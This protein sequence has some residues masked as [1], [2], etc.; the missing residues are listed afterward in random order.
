MDVLAHGQNVL[1]FFDELY[2]HLA[3][4]Q[5]LTSDWRLPDWLSS[6]NLDKL[7]P[8]E[9]IRTYL[10]YHDCGKPFCR[11]VDENG[12][13]HFPYH[14][15]ISY[16]TWLK[17]SNDMEV[18]ELIRRDMEA[19]NF[20]LNQIDD[21]SESKQATTLLLSALCELH[22]NAQMFGGIEST[23]F[24]IKWKRLN[25]LGKKVLMS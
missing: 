5:P 4:G 10:L 9:T 3:N 12:K 24:K 6:V 17:F 22:S 7:M 8:L 1:D 20:D 16:R 19:H 23:S 11:I 13:Q 14:A 25:R 18:A 15:E 21:F 2:A